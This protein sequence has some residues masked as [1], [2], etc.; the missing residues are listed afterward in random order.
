MMFLDMRGSFVFIQS[1]IQQIIQEKG[2]KKHT[3]KKHS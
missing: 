3:Q 1:Y 2:R